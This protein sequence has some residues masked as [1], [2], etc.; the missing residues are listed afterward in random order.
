M[1]Q[2]VTL[3]LVLGGADCASCAIGLERAVEEIP[4]V[5]SAAVNPIAETV[6]VEYDDQRANPGMFADRIKKTFGFQAEVVSARY[7]SAEGK[8]SEH[9]AELQK[10]RRK[11]AVGLF[12]SA[13]ILVLSFLPVLPEGI[14]NFVLFLLTTPV[15]FYV[16]GHFFD[17][18]LRGLKHRNANMDTLVS[19]GTGAAYLYS[20]IAT[21]LPG[22]FGPVVAE[23]YFDVAA[24]VIAL[25][26][27]GKYF[28]ARARGSANE[29][30]R[31][32]LEL[33]AKTARVVR[34]GREVDIP[35]EE[36]QVDDIVLVRP[37]EKI[38]VD[39]EVVEGYSSVDQSV[40]TGESIPV[41][42]KPGDAVIGA[43][44]NKTGAFKFRATK[45]GKDT[46]LAQIIQLVA[47]AQSSKAPIQRLIDRVTGYFTPIVI[48]LAIA[49]F[50]IWYIFGPAPGLTFALVNMVAVLVIA[51]PCA[52]GL[53][54]PTSIMI[55]AGKGAENGI[56]IKDAESLERAGKVTTVVFDKTGTLT[57]GKP[58]VTDIVGDEGR[59]LALAYSI[60]KTSEHSLAIPIIQKAKEVQVTALPVQDF[61]AVSGRGVRGTIEGQ[62]VLLGNRAMMEE[63]GI[64]LK[65]FDEPMQRLQSEGKTVM[66]LAAG[67]E[68][69][70]LIAVI[71]RPKESAQ[72]AVETLKA[73]GIEAMMITGDNQNTAQ[74]I[75]R[76]VGID[77]IIA[78]VLPQDKEKKIRALQ[79]R[80]KIVAM[81]G[82]GINDAP[83]LAAADLGIAMGTGTDVA[84]EAAGITLMNPDL[85]S[86]VTA[87]LLSKATLRNIKE[88]LVW[89]FGYNTT[90]IPVAMGILYPILGLL[91][92]PILAGAAMAFSSV[93]VVFNALRLRG[94]QPGRLAAIASE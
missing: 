86:V 45:V 41:E 1:K 13:P 11:V 93:S 12:L 34:D 80:D 47:E 44:I 7:G 90:L 36:V 67:Q 23:V 73:M 82:D 6:T 76:Q 48:M 78:N 55:A 35:V 38:P 15:M 58:V 46:V 75:A 16:G 20:S 85:R 14:D 70:G 84:I 27:L 65:D 72:P 53:A 57:E 88:N 92:N 31:K 66:A 87:I 68:A 89:A 29:A 39:G 25:V 43:S 10:L 56:L 33:G 60:E 17:S 2:K 71:D 69:L 8:E 4:G 37:G 40:V 74:A 61:Q 77:Q 26:M 5:S 50:T 32:L 64:A 24:V 51:C 54:T 83:A 19:I 18:F 30:I 52:M 9:G 94:F 81:V 62:T 28:E 42:K 79:E 3:Q 63:N 59:V 21:F 22:I 49:T 91:L